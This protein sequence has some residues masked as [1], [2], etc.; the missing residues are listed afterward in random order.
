MHFAFIRIFGGLFARFA[1]RVGG[2]KRL[3][4]LM[5]STDVCNDEPIQMRAAFEIGNFRAYPI[6]L[7]LISH[8]LTSSLS[9]SFSI[10]RKPN[11]EIKAITE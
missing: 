10:D 11:D 3:L 6:S 4:A 8:R 9:F 5:K 2:G 7:M 1:S